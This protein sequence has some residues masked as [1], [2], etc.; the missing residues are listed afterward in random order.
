M[1]CS[2]N[3][4]FFL[5]N[6]KVPL[7]LQISLLIEDWDFAIEILFQNQSPP[8]PP[9]PQPQTTTTT[10]LTLCKVHNAI[11]CFQNVHTHHQIP[12]YATVIILTYDSKNI[13]C[14]GD[15]TQQ[16]LQTTAHRHANPLW[17]GQ[18][19]HTI[20]ITIPTSTLLSLNKCSFQ[21]TSAKSHIQ[22]EIS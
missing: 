1:P 6:K 15:K 16:K 17:V 2:S 19:T 20:Q 18:H 7:L 8:P 22:Q 4:F 10:T 5:E 21:D 12:G 14:F 13:E 3:Q 11:H 9:P